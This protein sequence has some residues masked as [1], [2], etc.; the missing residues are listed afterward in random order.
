VDNNQKKD[1]TPINF[2]ELDFPPRPP[3]R[4]LFVFPES[5]TVEEKLQAVRSS[6][7]VKRRNT[8]RK[9]PCM[10]YQK[11]IIFHFYIKT[12]QGTKTSCSQQQMLS[13][14]FLLNGHSISKVK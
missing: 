14:I 3:P 7:F 8:L 12:S 5:A 9:L 2:D 1:D 11:K 10:C 13:A 6:K 4:F